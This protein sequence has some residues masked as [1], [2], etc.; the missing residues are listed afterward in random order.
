LDGLL[1]HDILLIAE[2]TWPG[3]TAVRQGDRSR[4]FAEVAADARSFA[5]ALAARGVRARDRVAVLSDTAL[6]VVALNFALSMLGA[7]YVPLNPRWR[8][9]EVSQ[10]LHVVKPALLV[11][12][13]GH[14]GEVTITELAADGRGKTP[15]DLAGPRETHTH[16]M[17]FTSGTTGIPK[18]AELSHRADRLRAMW[19]APS[20]PSGTH[21]CAF[22]QF[23]MAGWMW[24]QAAWY[25]GDEVVL[26]EGNDTE[27][28]LSAIERFGGH[29]FYGLP[30]VLRR[31]M[32][33]DLSRYNL[34]S[35]QALYT[36][37]SATSAEF[38][39]AVDEAFRGALTGVVYGSTEA[40]MA[41][42]LKRE[43]F[44]RKPGSVG[45]PVPPV[46]ARVDD[47]GQ[48]WLHGPTLF[49]GYFGRPDAT[50]DAFREGWLRTGELAA[51]DDEGYLHIIGRSGD[52]IRTG[53][54]SVAPAEVEDVLRG[55][56]SIADVAVIGVPDSSW[57]ELVVA[58][59]VLRPGRQVEVQDLRRHCDGRLSAYKQPRQVLI[60]EEIPRTQ[61]TMQANRGW[62]TAYAVSQL[63]TA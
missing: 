27:G 58:C 28:I 2:R 44:D 22:P 25:A 32:E 1:Y 21:V 17:F 48:L 60:V 10:A 20:W 19:H 6:D 39:K 43:D 41:S 49:S 37:T 46:V 23:H 57:G 33:T 12:D 36:G 26:V 13:D 54:E 5:A 16:V 47:D 45:L 62:L 31:M 4:T 15:P 55:H 38:I 7:V 30:A 11:A 9:A 14:D 18:A 63:R 53:G 56:E 50:Q 35:L 29:S 34:T 8:A 51:R 59:V 40:G 61:A 3:R 42:F 52:V 24:S